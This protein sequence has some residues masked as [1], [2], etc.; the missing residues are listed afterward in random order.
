MTEELIYRGYKLCLNRFKAGWKVF[1]YAPGSIL[2]ENEIPHTEDPN[3]R[4]SVL[5]ESRAVV[6]RA[7]MN[8]S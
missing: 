8:A 6:D 3:G 7:L 1:I 4:E 2:A 5:S